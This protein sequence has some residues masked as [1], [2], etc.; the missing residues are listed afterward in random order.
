MSARQSRKALSPLKRDAEVIRRWMQGCYPWPAEGH[1]RYWWTVD[2]LTLDALH[3]VEAR[4]TD[5]QWK[6]YVPRFDAY[7]TMPSSNWFTLSKPFL[8]ATAE[9]K[10]A[11]LAAVIREAS[12]E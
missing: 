9:Q 8:H 12:H 6:R 3:E 10:I 2:P 11:A 7:S 4:L 5:E 1:L